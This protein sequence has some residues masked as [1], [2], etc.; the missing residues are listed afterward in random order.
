[1][2]FDCLY[3]SKFI[4][5]DLCFLVSMCICHVLLNQLT[6]LISTCFVAGNNLLLLLCNI[7]ENIMD[8]HK[9][10]TINEYKQMY[11]TQ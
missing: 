9:I 3:V 6:D 11:A 7:S 4:C 8:G 5:F 1:M 2:L 10:L